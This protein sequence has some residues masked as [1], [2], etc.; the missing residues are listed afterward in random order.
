MLKQAVLLL[1]FGSASLLSA[2]NGPSLPVR[3]SGSR[4]EDRVAQII[5]QMRSQSGLIQLRRLTPSKEELQ[6][7]CTA[8]VTGK[9]LHEPMFG[10][11]QIYFADDVSEQAE[12]LKV[13]ALGSSLDSK[14]NTRYPVYADKDWG[15]FSVVVFAV[16]P[17]RNNSG[18]Y[19]IGVA[20]HASRMKE[21]FSPMTFDHPVSNSEDWKM[22][23][24]TEC[25]VE[26]P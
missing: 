11:L 20:R 16:Q 13:V 24:A 2:Q 1:M 5:G 22:Q 26:R 17:S 15:R 23:I 9:S 21:L 18:T 8:A 6:L 25:R 12:A 10:A 14:T 3:M 7:V 4:G 19:A